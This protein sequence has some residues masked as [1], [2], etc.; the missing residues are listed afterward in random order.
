V[1]WLTPLG[2]PVIQPYRKMSSKL[3]KTVVQRV[4][5]GDSGDH[6]P[7]ARA[8][9]QSA[10]APNFVHSIDSSHMLLTAVEC[11]ARGMEFAAVHDSFWTHAA[12]VD[13]MNKVL[14]ETFVRLHTR[15]LLVELRDAMLLRNPDVRLPAL[16]ERGS[17]DLRQVLESP[18][19]FS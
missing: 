11:K 13:D 3:I 14:R 19:F 4:K 2:L 18:Y 9:Q 17:L 6:M 10:F 16:P 8:R 7:V 5:I 12:R 1:Q 15:E